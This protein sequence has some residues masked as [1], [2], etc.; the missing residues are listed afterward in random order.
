MRQCDIGME[1]STHVIIWTQWFENNT[2]ELLPFCEWAT[3]DDKYMYAI[4]DRALTL[5]VYW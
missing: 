1:N 2:S 4:C 3:W 5:P